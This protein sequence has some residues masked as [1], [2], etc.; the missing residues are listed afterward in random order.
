MVSLE[1]IQSYILRIKMPRP[2][3]VGLTSKVSQ[4]YKWSM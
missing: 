2:G 4:K 1:A 3:Q